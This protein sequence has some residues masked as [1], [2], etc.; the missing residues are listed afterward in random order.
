MSAPRRRPTEESLARLDTALTPG[1]RPRVA[2]E[3]RHRDLWTRRELLAALGRLE[4][5]PIPVVATWFGR[6]PVALQ[7][8]LERVGTSL[9]EIRQR[10]H[11]MHPMDVAAAWGVERETM[12]KW[13][14]RGTIPSVRVKVGGGYRRVVDPDAILDWLACRGALLPIDPPDPIWKDVIDEARQWLRRYFVNQQELL[15]MLIITERGLRQRRSRA[16][17][18]VPAFHVCGEAF[19]ARLSVAIWLDE[20]ELWTTAA[21]D[22]L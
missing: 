22:G 8:T 4:Y 9:S 14:H 20:H 15:Q 2:P 18:P 1:Y 11:G 6:S 10:A 13:L 5:D 17:F 3:S 19:Y 16:G 12:Q 21:R 7:R